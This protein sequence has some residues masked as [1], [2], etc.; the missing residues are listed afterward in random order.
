MADIIQDRTSGSTSIATRTCALISELCSSGV[1]DEE[2]KSMLNGILNAHRPMAVLHNCIRYFMEGGDPEKFME[3][4]R[5]NILK[6][7]DLALE[8][9]TGRGIRNV[10]TISSSSSVEKTLSFFNGTIYVMESRPMLEG[11]SMA[12]RLVK[13]GRDV[14]VVTDAYGISMV[15]RGDVDAVI[16]GA[17]AVYKGMLINKVG[18]YALSA[19]ARISDTE[20][21]ALLTT[22]KIFPEDVELTENEIMQFHDPEEIT[23]RVKGINPYFEAVKID[24]GITVFTEKGILD[25]SYQ[26]PS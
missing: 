9:I 25:I 3:N 5:K 2:V 12:E 21:I 17:D 14:R 19:A 13:K 4:M 15:A 22:E 8:Y 24:N 16:V 1:A 6:A 18:T 23:D 20:F 10:I 11:I 7:S 26:T